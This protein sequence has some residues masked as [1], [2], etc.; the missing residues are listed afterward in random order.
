MGV[1]I[2]GRVDRRILWIDVEM[3]V[4]NSG[5]PFV[6]RGLR[7][8][9]TLLESLRERAPGPQPTKVPSDGRRCR[10][11]LDFGSSF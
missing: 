11:C 1:K 6:K 5:Q 2:G 7:A 4:P 9:A 10:S 8:S 3:K